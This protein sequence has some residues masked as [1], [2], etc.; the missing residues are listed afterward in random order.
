MEGSR[1]S[2]PSTSKSQMPQWAG[3]GLILMAIA[4]FAVFGSRNLETGSLAEIGPGLFPK[5]LAIFLMIAAVFLLWTGWQSRLGADRI[6]FTG[7]SVRAVIAILGAVFVFGLTVRSLG[8]AFATPIAILVSGFADSGTRWLELAIFA[9][10]LT[11][12]CAV[13][14]RF[15]LGLPIPLAPWLL[16]Y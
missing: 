13:L 14:F 7:R 9:S 3:G 10:A 16:G 4:G 1:E 5:A 8:L 11:A 12:F 2:G 15:A 6:N